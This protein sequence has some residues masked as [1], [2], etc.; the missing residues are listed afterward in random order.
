ML[1]AFTNWIESIRGNQKP[2]CGLELAVRV[3]TLI[4]LAEI[5]ERKSVT[6]CFDAAT[7]TV[8]DGFGDE[9]KPFS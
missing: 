4:S 5:S 9:I 3:Q 6:C 2:N 7:R 8:H 1:Y